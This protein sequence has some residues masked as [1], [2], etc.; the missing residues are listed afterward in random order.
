MVNLTRSFIIIFAL[1]CFYSCKNTIT[2]PTDPISYDTSITYTD[3]NG[4]ILGGDMTD[5]C[6]HCSGTSCYGIKPVYPNP[7]TDTF[8]IKYSVAS[9]IPVK[10][11]YLNSAD[12]VFLVN[13]TIESGQYSLHISANG[14][15]LH[16]TYKKLFIQSGGFYCSGDVKFR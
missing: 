4:V 1:I 13:S 10:L 5:W 6:Y 8:N 2:S 12:T 3:N 14:H 16:N 9:A 11:Y 7:V 15:G